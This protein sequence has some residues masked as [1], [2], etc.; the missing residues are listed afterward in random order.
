MH[1]TSYD[2]LNMEKDIMLQMSILKPYNKIFLSIPVAI[3][4]F[5]LGTLMSMQH[6]EGLADPGSAEY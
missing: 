6:S 1:C 5:Q 4:P 3:Y 2:H